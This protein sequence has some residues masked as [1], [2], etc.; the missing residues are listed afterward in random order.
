M[1]GIHL[2]TRFINHLRRDW[3]VDRIAVAQSGE[4]TL[5]LRRLFN[6]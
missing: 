1:R 4:R 3:F 2:K 6:D 5:N